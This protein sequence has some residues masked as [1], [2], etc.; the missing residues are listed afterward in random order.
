M[1]RYAK[2]HPMIRGLGEA[3]L[4]GKEDDYLNSLNRRGRRAMT[5][6]ARKAQR[7]ALKRQERFRRQHEGCHTVGVSNGG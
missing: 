5:A 7:V 1:R 2:T 3:K 6:M 4:L